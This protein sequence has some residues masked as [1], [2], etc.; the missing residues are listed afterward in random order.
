MKMTRGPDPAMSSANSCTMQ[1]LLD[2]SFSENLYTLFHSSLHVGVPHVRLY[3][4]VVFR[5]PKVMDVRREKSVN[6]LI[7]IGNHWGPDGSFLGPSIVANKWMCGASLEM[8]LKQ[9]ERTLS[10]IGSIVVGKKA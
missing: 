6:A 1:S 5:G 9:P 7:A 8:G 2:G 4:D 10:A 3:R